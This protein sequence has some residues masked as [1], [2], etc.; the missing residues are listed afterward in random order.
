ME[1]DFQA[2]IS[3]LQNLLA[4]EEAREA[5]QPRYAYEEAL[6]RRAKLFEMLTHVAGQIRTLEQR[7]YNLPRMADRG[8]VEWAEAVRKMPNLIFLVLDTT[9]VERDADILR[10][11]VMGRDGGTELDT[12]VRPGRHN[13]PN[14]PYTGLSQQDIDTAPTLKEAWGEILS[15]LEGKFVLSYGLDFVQE[16][17]H[18]NADAYGLSRVQLIGEC[19]MEFAEKYFRVNHIRLQDAAARIGWST[20]FRPMAQVRA[21]AQLELLR[22]MSEGV[23]QV[24]TQ[25]DEDD[26]GSL[27]DHPF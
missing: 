27:D 8:Y 24:A 11:V 1:K 3:E 2:T 25:S 6:E 21:Y 20:P 9:G 7:A 5:P 16:R 4:H 15:V 10:V 14:T 17:L 13:R 23:T 12:I 26:L 19:L 18:E 22:A